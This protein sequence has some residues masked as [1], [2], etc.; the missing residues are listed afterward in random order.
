MAP[1]IIVAAL[2]FLGTLFG[3][4]LG[5]ITSNKLTIYRVEQLEKKVDKHNN[6]IDRMYK[7]ESRLD[8][9]END[10]QDIKGSLH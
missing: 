4:I 1:E 7:V 3:S 10:I 2:S 8:T 6:L 5:I 9:M